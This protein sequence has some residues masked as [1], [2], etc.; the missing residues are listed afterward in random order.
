MQE[1][2]KDLTNEITDQVKTQLEKEYD[3]KLKK[4]VESAKQK[5]VAAQDKKKDF[6]SDKKKTK[7]GR[8]TSTTPKGQ[9]TINFGKSND[10]EINKLK[11]EKEQAQKNYMSCLQNLEDFKKQNE[12]LK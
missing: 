7:G 4:E 1:A 10:D 8:E 12:Q 6:A 9:T 11:L 2:R 3:E 5:D